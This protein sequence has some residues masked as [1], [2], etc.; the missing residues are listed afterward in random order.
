LY[1]TPCLWLY[2]CS[3]I[4]SK[5]SILSLLEYADTHGII[6]AGD[7]NSKGIY[8]AHTERINTAAIKVDTF[9]TYLEDTVSSFFKSLSF[10]RILESGVINCILDGIF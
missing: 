3:L 8:N 5:G 7:F 10:I 2:L 1:K 4:L 9:M 6:I